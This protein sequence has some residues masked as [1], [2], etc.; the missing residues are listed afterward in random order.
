MLASLIGAFITGEAAN[1]VKRAKGA[2][3]AYVVV[4]LL[5]LTGVGFLVGAGYVAAARNLG[6]ITAAIAFGVG[7]ILIGAAVLGVR[8]LVASMRRSRSRRRGLDVATLAAAAAATVLPLLV[9]RGGLAGLLAPVAAVVAY[10]LYRESRKENPLP[11]DDP[12]PHDG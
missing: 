1:M 11:D 9:R 7:F 2:L 10:A 8:A 4:A 6:S 3:V 5:F 12:E